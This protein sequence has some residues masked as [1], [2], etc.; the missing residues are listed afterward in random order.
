M[1]IILTKEEARK[2]L[3]YK[4]GLIDDYKFQ[5]KN[6]IINFVKQV[7]SVQYDPLDM[8]GKN[9]ELVFQS[10][11]KGFTKA[12]LNEVLYED[13]KLLDY[14]DKNLAII[15]LEDW[16]NLQRM[17]DYHYKIGRGK[18]QIEPMIEEAK[19]IIKEKSYVSSKD[20]PFQDKVGWYW[21][22]TTLSRAILETMYFRGQ[23]VIHH[24]KGTIKYYSLI[25][26]YL[27]NEIIN[28][29]DEN[30]TEYDYI[31]WRLYRRIKAIGLLWNKASDAFLYMQGLTSA[32]RNQIYA[33]LLK[34]GKIVEVKVE[35]IKEPLYCDS[36]DVNILID[37]PFNDLKGRMEFIAPLDNFIWDRKL[38]EALFDYVYRWEVYVPANKRQ[39]GYY[40]LPILADD[41]FIGRL[42]VVKEKEELVIKKIWYENNID[43]SLYQD[44]LKECLERFAKFNNCVSIKYW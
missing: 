16:P 3:L 18:E 31:K 1:R 2:F 11:V 10:R 4:H 29:E 43:S 37:K 36:N 25:E 27:P 7:G 23:L 13:R 30:K 6:G 42:E 14:F 34:E 15:P 19:L 39:Y 28:K 26:D 20:L 33:D 44:R 40:V 35:G 17:R 41:K 8:C 9:S 21:S 32:I 5:G 12:M 24:K 38:I 22:P